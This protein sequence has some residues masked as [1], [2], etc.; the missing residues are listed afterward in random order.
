M[1]RKGEVLDQI[2]R[3]LSIWSADLKLNG[4]IN[5]LSDHVTSEDIAAG[6][7]DR[8]YGY[9]LKNANEVHPNHKAVDLVDT[10]AEDGGGV[11]VQISTS[12]TPQKAKKTMK[13]FSDGSEGEALS[14]EYS[15]LIIL[16]L[17]TDDK[18]KNWDQLSGD[19]YTLS[20]LNLT[21]LSTAIEHFELDRLEPILEYLNRELKLESAALEQ[22][23]DRV[24]RVA[25]IL[26][27]AA[28]AAAGKSMTD[29]DVERFYMV[30]LNFQVMLK[31]ISND[32]DIPHRDMEEQLMKL[33][34]AGA[35]VILT[36]HSGVG[37]SVIMLC[38]AVNWVRR[39]GIAIWMEP[40]ETR[41]MDTT[42]AKQ[43][44]R[45]ILSMI[46]A[47]GRALLCLDA[48]ALWSDAFEVLW[49]T[50]TGE[51]QIQILM[52]ER[53]NR[54]S[55]MTDPNGD[56]LHHRVEGTTVVAMMAENKE[57]PLRIKDYPVIYIPEIYQRKRKI[58]EK[59][60]NV[61]F[62]LGA[63]RRI[64]E[65]ETVQR[66]MKDHN[67]NNVSLVEL[68]YRAQFWVRDFATKPE[69]LRMDWDEWRQILRK[70]LRLNKDA[71][72]LYGVIALCDLFE[73]PI[74]V[75]LFCRFF[76]IRES[77]LVLAMNRWRMRRQVE[78]VIF[79]EGSGTLVPKH[80]VA[81]ELF[82]Q[83]HRHQLPVHALVIE[84]LQTMDEFEIDGFLAQNVRKTA[85]QR[86]Y[87][88]LVGQLRYRDYF[89]EIYNRNQRGTCG[90]YGEAKARLCLGLLYTVPRNDWKL[91]EQTLKLV[92]HL[93]PVLD[94]SVL[95]ASLYTE[96]GRLLADGRQ[97]RDAEEKFLMVLDADHRNIHSRTELGRLLAKQPG[98]EGEAEA[99]LQ[100]TIRLK[101]EDI[102]S[103]TELGRLLSKQ[104][105]REG[106]AEAFLREAIRI[107]PKNL[108][109]H[110]EL[111]RL[112][113]KQ[114]GREGE[115]EAFLRE[116]IRL[117]PEDIQ[118]RTELGRLLSKQPGREQEAEDFLRETIR[119]K[120]E[121]IQ[122]RTELGRLLSK[123]PGREGEAEA[124]LLETL[125]IDPKHIH[126]RTELGRLLSKQPGRE[127]EAEAFLR[128]AIRIDPKNLHPH[129]ELGRLLSKQP[130]REEEAVVFLR[131]ILDVDPN[132]LHTR[133]EL[134]KLCI[135]SG[136]R[137]EAERLYREV[138]KLEP[139][140]AYAKNGL[141]SL[142]SHP[143]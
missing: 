35:P 116:T 75:S 88:R 97:V 44:C 78:P 141:K 42:E 107:D 129:T 20:I 80:D 118:S 79:R 65:G 45:D 58:L 46:P 24:A 73:V 125:K 16:L 52:A 34:S 25:H 54:L 138:L 81:A 1:T 90:L 66:I 53:F 82:F 72:V 7:L 99:F 17:T 139:G 22:P 124:F 136:S 9:H 96:W 93:D 135:K 37:K 30:D 5:H 3:G 117:K 26:D 15:K 98:R 87:H 83:F 19:G 111:G 94:G 36:G 48:P 140:N 31:V 21:D 68:I 4:K 119:L 123:Q 40:K 143:N 57:N 132:N 77:E 10:D 18:F 74:T 51:A 109:S 11:A 69:N 2:R 92:E 121:D 13:G 122:S 6:L 105:G 103:R 102:Q 142:S 113:S 115:A 95:T 84:L 71:T 56:K 89:M 126:S 60:V 91:R 47:G 70:E 106:E 76:E 63:V 49:E 128:E 108:H 50:C 12:N 62:G 23:R 104:P 120:P 33:C 55:R 137:D 38:A 27:A 131:E 8:I 39:G 114:P 61:M 41:K 67:R 100:E 14:E 85:V 59:T 130:G 133:I 101:P 112:L 64:S 32:R 86:G 29:G 134:A 127:E 28:V 43:F 110:T